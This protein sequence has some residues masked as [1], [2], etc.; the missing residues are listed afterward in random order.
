MTLKSAQEHLKPLVHAAPLCLPCFFP[1]NKKLNIFA[2][3]K[4]TTQMK[5]ND[6][7]ETNSSDILVDDIN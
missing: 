4:E 5:L 7:F 1:Q 6:M 2:S 3:Q